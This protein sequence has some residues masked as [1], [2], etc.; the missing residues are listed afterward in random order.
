MNYDLNELCCSEE[1]VEVS[2]WNAEVFDLSK[3]NELGK[4][5][6]RLVE[7][8]LNEL[9]HAERLS[10]ENGSFPFF[11][12]EKYE[13]ALEFSS[14]KIKHIESIDYV[15]R[16]SLDIYHGNSLVVTT[17]LN[18]DINWRVYRKEIPEVWKGVPIF[19]VNHHKEI[20]SGVSNNIIK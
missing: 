15:E 4:L 11:D 9:T 10:Y 5:R 6:A 3:H 19:V 18:R 13:E 14:S 8:S 7:E 17:W 12:A 2:G 20:E 16:V 1:W